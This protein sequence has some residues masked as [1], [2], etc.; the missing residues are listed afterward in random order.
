M[1][2]SLAAFALVPMT[3][4]QAAPTVT[5]NPSALMLGQQVRITF[6]NAPNRVGDDVVLQR[7]VDGSWRRHMLKRLQP[8][9]GTATFYH[10]PTA[11]GVE[12]YRVIV[13]RDGNQPTLVSAG[14]PI[15]VRRWR[16]LVDIDPAT[17]GGVASDRQEGAVTIDGL[18]FDRGLRY[19]S[20]DTESFNAWDLSLLRCIEYRG[21]HGLADTSDPG[22]E[23]EL[24]VTIDPEPEV[25]AT[26]AIDESEF[27]ILDI[28]GV[29]E[30]RL[31]QREVTPQAVAAFGNPRI[32][33]A[34]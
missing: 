34:S 23:G 10:R 31:A 11:A 22:A 8:P 4:A 18:S 27:K 25:Q 9:N 14:Q 33:C 12:W 6:A 15:P 28:A 7:K 2:W 17:V 29:D 21:Y 19:A 24:T 16:F 26:Y 3:P 32:L 13:P 1:L 5:F 30:L 20:V